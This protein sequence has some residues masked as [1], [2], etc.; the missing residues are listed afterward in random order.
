MA[1]SLRWLEVE[2]FVIWWVDLAVRKSVVVEVRRSQVLVE[3]CLEE[4]ELGERP[5]R[6]MEKVVVRVGYVV[7]GVVVAFLTSS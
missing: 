2:S 4:G 7:E 3:R 1:T 5:L 6:E